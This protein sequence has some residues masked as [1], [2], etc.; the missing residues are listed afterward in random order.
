MQARRFDEAKQYYTRAENLGTPAGDYSYY[1]LALV[2]G[3]QKNYDGKVALLNQL[4]NKYPNSPY[5]INALYEKGRSYV[6]SRNNSQAIATF[7]ELL[8]KYPESPV[9][10]KAAAEI[11]L[12]YYQN[13]DYDRAIEAYKHVITKY[14][15][16]EEARLAMRDLKSIYVEANRVDEFAALAA[17]M[18]GA[19]RFEPSEQ[20]SLTYIAA[21]KVYMKGELTPAKASFTRYLQS[22]PN[23]AFSLNAHYYLSI[24]GKEQKDEVAVLEHAGKLLEYPDSPY[25]EE[26]LLMRGEIL[27]NHKEYEQAMADYKQL[28][29]RA[30]TAERRQLGA[31]GVLRCGA[32]LK[33]DIEVIQAAT[34][35]LTEAKLTPELQNEA[36]YYRAK[37]YLN[38][39]AV[40]KQRT[41]S[42][43]WQ[44][45]PVR[46]TVRKLNS[47]WHNRCTTPVNM[48]PQKKK[49]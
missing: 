11:G 35:L 10:R 37:A 33:D 48:L 20:D 12:L 23:G 29:A 43:F 13:D 21:E 28:Q 1:Q 38:Q 7:R 24:I 2:A 27:F 31:T 32:L 46:Y 45:I 15:G 5:A 49:S 19:I 25:S 40:K 3:L 6:Q 17:Q 39:K 41:T 4:A 14:P 16:S 26:A 9:S 18:P 44:K 8:N 42:N 36:L 22:Y 34:T 47:W 30:T